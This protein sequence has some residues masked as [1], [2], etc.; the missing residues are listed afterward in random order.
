M[1]HPVGN[2]ERQKLNGSQ[3]LIS[4]VFDSSTDSI[5]E[6]ENIKKLN[7]FWMYQKVSFGD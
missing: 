6:K 7:K 1:L 5:S 2:D 3:G 4:V